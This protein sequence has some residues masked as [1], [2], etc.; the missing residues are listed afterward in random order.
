MFEIGIRN[1]E[2]GDTVKRK[3]VPEDM[4]EVMGQAQITS[5]WFDRQDT[6][7]SGSLIW[8]HWKEMG[9][10]IPHIRSLVNGDALRE[11]SETVMVFDGMHGVEHEF[12]VERVNRT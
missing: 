4:G 9:K 12:Y 1:T 6:C 8:E 3:V 5:Q 11:V 2:T 7:F 10:V